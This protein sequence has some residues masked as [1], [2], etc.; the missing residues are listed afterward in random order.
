MLTPKQA[1]DVLDYRAPIDEL[2]VA[3]GIPAAHLRQGSGYCRG[4]LDGVRDRSC[5][6][7]MPALRIIGVIFTVFLLAAINTLVH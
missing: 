5:A 7:K 6:R 3:D 4:R 2:G 1:F